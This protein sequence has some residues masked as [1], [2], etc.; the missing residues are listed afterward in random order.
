MTL[1]FSVLFIFYPDRLLLSEQT[2]LV[3]Q[4]PTEGP[5]GLCDGGE[6][7]SEG[8]EQVASFLIWQPSPCPTSIVEAG[9]EASGTSINP[10]SPKIL[11]HMVCL[12]LMLVLSNSFH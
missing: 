9:G 12:L 7:V 4:P 10:S 1:L 5:Q 11:F 3:F 6:E 8:P 2:S